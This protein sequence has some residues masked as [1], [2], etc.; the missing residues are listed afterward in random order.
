MSLI[1]GPEKVR[2]IDLRNDFQ[3]QIFSLPIE[4]FAPNVITKKKSDG[5]R[6]RSHLLV[7]QLMKPCYNIPGIPNG[8]KAIM[9]TDDIIYDPLK[10]LDD[11]WSKEN[12][13]KKLTEY[14]VEQE[15]KADAKKAGGMNNVTSILLSSAVVILVLGMAAIG[16]MKYYGG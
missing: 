4:E 11:S 7:R 12:I 6:E 10:Q 13:R 1:T 3:M 16:L 15:H 9:V 8:A 2:I 14:A 5:T